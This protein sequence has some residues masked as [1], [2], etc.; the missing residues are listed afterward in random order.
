MGERKFPGDLWGGCDVWGGEVIP[1]KGP[2]SES[3]AG[4]P[5]STG[6]FTPVYTKE[7]IC[8]VIRKGRIFNILAKLS[9]LV[10]IYFGV[11]FMQASDIGVFDFALSWNHWIAFAVI[12]VVWFLWPNKELRDKKAHLRDM[13]KCF[14]CD[15]IHSLKEI[16]ERQLGADGCGTCLHVME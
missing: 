13:V 11:V 7:E 12:S 16:K 8:A 5:D 3:T 15:G 1:E 14:S 10:L 4:G 6:E 9:C 2:A